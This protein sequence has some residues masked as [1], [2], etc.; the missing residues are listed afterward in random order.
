MQELAKIPNSSINMILC[1]L[2]YGCTQNNWDIS[3]NIKGLWIEYK[4]IIAK[5]G[6]IALTA[7]ARLSAALINN[8][9]K[10]FRYDLIWE[11]YISTGFL[12]ANRMPLRAHESILIFYKKLPVYNPQMIPGKPY[13]NRR[14]GNTTTNYG[15]FNENTT[16][17]KGDRYPRS[18]KKI[19]HDHDKIHPTQKPVALFEYLIKTYSSEGDT[20]L[21]NCLGGGTTAIACINTKR[22][23]IGIEKDTAIFCS[24]TKRVNNHLQGVV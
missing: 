5:N 3:L 20:V 7:D 14:S 2:P 8:D 4:R 23:Y 18:V 9:P 6:V 13:K 17:N 15:K 19:P 1:D 11:K 24:A 22:N 21:D 16:T 10:L 12:N